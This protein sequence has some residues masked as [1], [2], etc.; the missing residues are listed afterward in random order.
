M[1]NFMKHIVGSFS[2]V[3]V[4]STQFG[5]ACFAHTVKNHFHLKD[6]NEVSEIQNAIMDFPT[7]SGHAT[8]IGAALKV[9]ILLQYRHICI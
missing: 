5:A 7:R 6:H 3:G 1:K 4:T 2:N 8:A 9:F